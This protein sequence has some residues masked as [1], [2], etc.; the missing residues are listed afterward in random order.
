MIS[1]NYILFLKVALIKNGA[2]RVV[3]IVRKIATIIICVE[4]P[5]DI[6]P[7][8]IAVCEMIRTSSILGIIPTPI[9]N[10]S[11]LLIPD[12]FAPN[13]KGHIFFEW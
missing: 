2:N 10:D 3:V 11:D 4:N 5:V 7:W 13:P 6:I 12:I 1:D 8:S 9:C